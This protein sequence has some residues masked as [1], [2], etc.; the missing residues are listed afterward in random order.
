[1]REEIN[2]GLGFP[3]FLRIIA[4][5]D[6]EAHGEQ[7]TRTAVS[8]EVHDELSLFSPSIPSPGLHHLLCP[9]QTADCILVI[10]YSTC[11]QTRLWP[12]P[13]TVV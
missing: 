5:E 10:N 3:P 12:V 6:G 4:V 11:P 2:A 7:G 9:Q 1:M 13:A 8:G